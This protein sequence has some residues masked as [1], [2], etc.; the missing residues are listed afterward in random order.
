MT[1]P[2]FAWAESP[3]TSKTTQPRLATS[4]FGDGYEEIA[5]D[6]LNAMA[7][8]W[9][10]S[11][12]GVSKANG[13][14]IVA[15]FEARFSSVNGL[16]A[17]SWWPLWATAAIKVTCRSWTRTQGELPDESDITATFTRDFRP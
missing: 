11:F 8:E 17:F 1:T 14:E 16:E 2:V 15:F 12:R 4:K 9:Q 3:G 7:A 6:G 5:P 13:D 10:L